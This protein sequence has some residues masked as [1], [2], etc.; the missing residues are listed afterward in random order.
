MHNFIVD[1]T[2]PNTILVMKETAR[3]RSVN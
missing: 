2:R 1:N 3:T